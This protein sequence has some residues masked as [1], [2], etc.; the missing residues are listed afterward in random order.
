MEEKKKNKKNNKKKITY[1]YDAIILAGG[2]STRMGFP[3]PWLKH[4]DNSSFVEKLVN[5]YSDWGCNRIVVVINDK[6]LS[7]AMDNPI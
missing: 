4:N 7:G 3:K 5:T 6:L 2:K 1:T